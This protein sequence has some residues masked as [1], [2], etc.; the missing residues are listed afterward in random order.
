MITG[1]CLCRQVRYEIDEPPELM[2]ICHCS[3]CRKI[4][5][6]S[7]GVF[8]HIH[9]D[10]FHWLA[11]DQLVSKYVSSPDHIRAFCPTCGSSVPNENDDYVCIP[12]GSF[13]T[14]PQVTPSLQIFA[15]S[16][17]PWHCISTEP[18]AYDEFDWDD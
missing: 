14:D 4:T 10:K 17:A 13:D 2:N 9:S 15:T 12:A 11:G 6:S 8:A 3:M 18:P 5:G 7:Y 1:S 16:K